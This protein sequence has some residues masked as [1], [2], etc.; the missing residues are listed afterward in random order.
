MDD[1]MDM[2]EADIG[3]NQEVIQGSRDGHANANVYSR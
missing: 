3:F 2:D 1:D